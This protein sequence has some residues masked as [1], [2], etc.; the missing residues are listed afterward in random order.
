ML[1][2]IY[3]TDVEGGVFAEA[4]VPVTKPLK[5]LC[6]SYGF[7]SVLLSNWSRYDVRNNRITSY[8]TKEYVIK[9]FGSKTIDPRHLRSENFAYNKFNDDCGCYYH[10][11]IDDEWC[12]KSGVCKNIISSCWLEKGRVA[13]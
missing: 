8:Y 1:S 13:G 4:N 3:S 2:M 10:V 7:H 12:C 11:T 6:Q 9:W 5:K